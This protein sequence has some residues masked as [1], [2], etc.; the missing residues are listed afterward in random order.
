MSIGF[1]RQEYWSGL[2]FPSPGDRPDPEIKPTSLALQADSL[3]LSQQ[4]CLL[5]VVSPNLYRVLYSIPQG[6]N[7]STCPL[8]KRTAFYWVTFHQSVP[9]S[10]NTLCVAAFLMSCRSDFSLHEKG[11]FKAPLFYC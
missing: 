2:P 10:L 8:Q 3:P 9:Q 4:G 7:H 1:P 6:G 11:E 5:C